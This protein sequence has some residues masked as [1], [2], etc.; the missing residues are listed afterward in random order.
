MSEGLKMLAI[1]TWDVSRVHLCGDARRWIYTYLPAKYE[2]KAQLART[3][4]ERE[5]QRQTGDTW[6]EVLKVGSMKVGTACLAF[7]CSQDGNLK[8]LCH[9]DDFSVVARRE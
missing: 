4:T 6:F 3:C 5:M 8:G 1:A 9:G 7:F 2:Q